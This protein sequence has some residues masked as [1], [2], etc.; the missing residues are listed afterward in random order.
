MRVLK[1]RELQIRKIQNHE[2]QG[3]PVHANYCL[4][5]EEILILIKG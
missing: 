2:L 1:N 5:V 4:M 3:L